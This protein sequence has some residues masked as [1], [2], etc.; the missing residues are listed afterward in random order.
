MEGGVV[1]RLAERLAAL[2]RT[3]DRVLVGIDGPDAA[4]KTTLADRLAG[5][6]PVPAVRASVDGFHRP[7]A[8]RRRQG[9]LSAA[10]YY[11][12]A[13]DHEAL[14]GR[15]LRPFAGGAGRVA[16]QIF[17]HLADA[18]AEVLCDVPPQA[19]LVVDGVFVQRDVLR[20]FWTLSVYLHAPPA[21]TLRRALVRDDGDPADIERRY[22][23]RYLPAQALY[24]TQAEPLASADVVLDNTDPAAPALV[25]WPGP[26]GS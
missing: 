5:R 7:R 12:D 26:P 21:E 20:G 14:V 9:D 18:P 19:V 13:Y 6:L 23:E 15:L 1:D 2:A 22:R 10:G 25:R 3:T 11:C 16:T 8:V 4:G 17:D 24:R